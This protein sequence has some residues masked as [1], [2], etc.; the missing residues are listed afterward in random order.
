MSLTS[1]RIPS[2]SPPPSASSSSSASSTRYGL[3][4]SRVWARSQGHRRRRS[5]TIARARPSAE[6]SCIYPPRPVRFAPVSP[7][8]LPSDTARSW[9]DIDLGALVA[10]ART[11]AE[12]SGTRLLPMVKANGYGLGAARVAGALEA[13]DPWGYGVATVDEGVALRAAGIQR[14]ILV[15]SP[16]SPETLEPIEEHGFRPAIGDPEMLRCWLARSTSPFHLEI[17]SGMSRAGFRWDDERRSPLRA[18]PSPWPPDGKASS[19]IFTPR[20]ATPSR[21]RFSGAG[22]RRWS[23]GCRAGRSWCMP[24]TARRPSSGEYAADMVRPGIFLYGGEAGAHA[25]RPR[26]VA[27][28]RA[29][30]LAV[31]RVAAGESVSYGAAWCASRPTTVATLGVGYADGVH[32]D[33]D[34]SGGGATNGRAAG[35]PGAHRR[36]GHDGPDHGGGGR[37]RGRGG[38]RG[39]HLRRAR[40]ARPAGGRHRDDFLRAADLPGRPGYRGD[41]G[42]PPGGDHRPRRRRHRTGPRHRRVWRY[43][44]RHP[45]Q[46]RPAGRRARPA[47]AGGPRIGALRSDRGD[48]CRQPLRARR[49]EAASRSVP[50]KTASPV[51]GRSAVSSF[52]PRFRRTRRVSRMP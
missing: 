50:G 31:R 40:L 1:P 35:P 3:R 14:P 17:D 41:T 12:A 26:T 21:L 29:R 39:D 24:P 44:K 45:G 7:M 11:I 37:R 23:A 6:L 32:R 5:R 27:A 46:R 16:L 10:N 8:T 9:V 30:V 2:G 28:L 48:S 33:A 22:F 52:R 38:R 43:R 34:R 15:V 36:A 42:D 4:V 51:T 25:P 18:R 20:T 19:P 49:T 13:L 47:E